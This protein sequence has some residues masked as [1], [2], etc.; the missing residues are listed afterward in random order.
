MIVPTSQGCHEDNMM[1]PRAWHTVSVSQGCVT[2]CLISILA[3]RVE[4][5][6]GAPVEVCAGVI[7]GLWGQ[8]NWGSP[9]SATCG[10]TGGLLP[11]GIKGW[12][13]VNGDQSP[14]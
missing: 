3:R 6:A 8:R 14:H 10:A 1:W 13:G 9:G 5:R 2:T 12:Y 4:L 11:D 7:L